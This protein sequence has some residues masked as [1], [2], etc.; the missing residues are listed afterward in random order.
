[1]LIAGKWDQSHKSLPW[2][3]AAM[4]TPRL[5]IVYFLPKAW[6]RGLKDAEGRARWVSRRGSVHKDRVFKKQLGKRGEKRDKAIKMYAA[7]V[8]MRGPSWKCEAV[9][10]A[11]R[12]PLCLRPLRRALLKARY[13]MDV[14][15]QSGEQRT[16]LANYIPNGCGNTNGALAAPTQGD[17]KHGAEEGHRLG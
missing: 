12:P 5:F 14:R 15:R 7:R 6:P 16:N 2:N 13:S 10:E 17:V 3:L 8:R 11:P 4:E 1:M 9:V